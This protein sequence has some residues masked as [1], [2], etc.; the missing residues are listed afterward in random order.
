MDIYDSRNPK[1]QFVEVKFKDPEKVAPEHRNKI[2]VTTIFALKPGS[3]DK[4][5][6]SAHIPL[7]TF[8]SHVWSEERG[9]YLDNEVK[10]I[11]HHMPLKYYDTRK[12]DYVCSLEFSEIEEK[13]E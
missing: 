9:S 8:S 7:K 3:T 5:D 11:Y 13:T 10:T 2:I 1:L 4:Y 6:V 12:L